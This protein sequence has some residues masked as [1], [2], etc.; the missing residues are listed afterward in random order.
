MVMTVML[1]GIGCRDDS[2]SGRDAEEGCVACDFRLDVVATVN[3]DQVPGAIPDRMIYF[4]PAPGNR[5]VTLR[6]DAT[7]LLV[8]DPAGLLVR[9]VRRGGD[10]PG[11]FCRICRLLAADLAVSAPHATLIHTYSPRQG[12][13]WLGRCIARYPSPRLLEHRI[14]GPGYGHLWR[15]A[16]R[17]GQA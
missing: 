15:G 5:L 1:A 8:F 14:T 13:C 17:A 4:D 3:G 9:R 11:E 2:T 6:L 12:G 16:G 10:G 7:S